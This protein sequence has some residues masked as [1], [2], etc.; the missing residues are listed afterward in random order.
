MNRSHCRSFG[1]TQLAL[2]ALAVAVGSLV[3]AANAQTV[4]EGFPVVNGSV[5]AI[6]LSGNTLYL[7]G[8]FTRIGAPSGSFVPF[9][10]VSGTAAAGFPKV[11]GS[12]E[13][14]ESDGAGGW[15]IGGYFSSVGGVPRANLAHVLSDLT[16]A[17]WNPG[18]D[19]PIEVLKLSGST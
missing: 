13:T 7:G 8:D 6:A 12:L 10:A 11:A 4:L 1:R 14:V 16:V 9:D 15:F 19:G 2:L 17:P 18:S 3:S 5:R